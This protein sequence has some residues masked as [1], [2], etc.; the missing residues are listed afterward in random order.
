MVRRHESVWF[1]S[2]EHPEALRPA[3]MLDVIGGV[4][5]PIA[6]EPLVGEPLQAQIVSVVLPD[7]GALSCF[8]GAVRWHRRAEHCAHSTGTLVLLRP[9]NGSI[10]VTQDG[11]H[12]TVPAGA[13]ILLSMDRPWSADLAVVK[14]I[15][16]LRLPRAALAAAGDPESALMRPVPRETAALQLLA[17]Y[18]GALLR[19]ILP[20]ANLNQRRTAAN[21]IQELTAFIFE[22][23]DAPD[24]AKGIGAARLRA[25][26]ADIEE[27]IGQTD[28]SADMI[29]ARH[30]V[31]SRYVQKLFEGEGISSFSRFV[32]E[33]RLARAWNLLQRPLAPERTISSIAFEVGFGDLSYFNRT[34]RRR[35]G[36]APSAARFKE[37]LP[38]ESP[39]RKAIPL[40]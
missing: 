25:I 14:R 13:A 7:L 2:E 3:L 23:Q 31:S 16:C 4:L 20:V 9:V 32:L 30:G 27:N 5:G 12:C 35:Y 17:H 26:K 15:D 36:V 28:L 29:A 24:R 21:H 33:C 1:V 18:G 19:G 22:G 34:F 10:E 37:A 6:I 8:V 11:R 40:A 38:Q 39:S